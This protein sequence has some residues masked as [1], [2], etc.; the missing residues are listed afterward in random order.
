[1]DIPRAPDGNVYYLYG[2]KMRTWRPA[3]RRRGKLRTKLAGPLTLLD[4]ET[5]WIL[6]A[7]LIAERIGN[8]KRS[9]FFVSKYRGLFV[10]RLSDVSRLTNQ[11]KQVSSDRLIF[12]LH[13]AYNYKHAES[14]LGQTVA[15]F[16][17]IA[18][19]P[20]S[21]WAT[22]SNACEATLLLHSVCL[23]HSVLRV[24]FCFI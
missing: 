6:Y 16:C 23:S 18:L 24:I 22:F 14:W 9:M 20:L 12:L 2:G 1:M 4:C 8:L 19:I 21:V 7:T 13:V 10:N 3:D 17:T 5:D 11:R 15:G